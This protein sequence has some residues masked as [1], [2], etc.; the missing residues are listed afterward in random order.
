MCL[1]AARFEVDQE[2]LA[3][4]KLETRFP[5]GT[6]AT[7][8]PNLY[9]ARSSAVS[10]AAYQYVHAWPHSI[11]PVLMSCLVYTLSKNQGTIP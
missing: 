4:E 8:R 2:A 10:P 9:C 5:R 11:Y 7:T 6:P 3:C 1:C